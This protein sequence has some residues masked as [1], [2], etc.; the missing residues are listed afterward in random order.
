VSA[1]RFGERHPHDEPASFGRVVVRDR[2]LEALALGR[3]LA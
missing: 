1:L 2:S 3:R